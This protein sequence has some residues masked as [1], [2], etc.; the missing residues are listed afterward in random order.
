MDRELEGM[1]DGQ[2]IDQLVQWEKVSGQKNK[3]FLLRLMKM[4]CSHEKSQILFLHISCNAK[5]FVVL[6]PFLGFHDLSLQCIDVIA[7]SC[8][9]S[10]K[11]KDKTKMYI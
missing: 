11:N 4:Q 8:E 1:L 7:Y 9:V 2:G 3:G 6:T 10:K 5:H